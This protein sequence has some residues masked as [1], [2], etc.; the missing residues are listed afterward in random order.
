MSADTVCHGRMEGVGHSQISWR[1]NEH[2]EGSYD[3]K[4]AAQGH[5]TTMTTHF[6][7]DWAKADCGAVKPFS[8]AKLLH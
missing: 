3:F 6:T 2:Y 1:G 8:A 5:S 4:G 7:G